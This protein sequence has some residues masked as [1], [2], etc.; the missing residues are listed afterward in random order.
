MLNLVAS[1]CFTMTGL[2]A[3]SNPDSILV[4]KVHI[5]DNLLLTSCIISGVDVYCVSALVGC[6]D[7]DSHIMEEQCEAPLPPQPH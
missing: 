4:S 6:V 1:I 7:V 2:G 5:I 3:L